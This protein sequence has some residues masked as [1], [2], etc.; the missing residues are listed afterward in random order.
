M[1]CCPRCRERIEN[2][3]NRL[4]AAASFPNGIPWSR[5]VEVRRILRWVLGIEP[6]S[7]LDHYNAPIPFGTGKPRT[8]T[9]E[10]GT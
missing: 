3:I 1:L 6:L 7:P 9:K 8:G 10:T 2:E 4:E 5:V